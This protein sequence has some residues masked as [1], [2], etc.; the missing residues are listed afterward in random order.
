MDTQWI[1]LARRAME[2]ITGYVGQQALIRTTYCAMVVQ[3]PNRN[4][5]RA[6]VVAEA[7]ASARG[8]VGPL[9]DQ[10]DSRLQVP[11][12]PCA[13]PTPDLSNDAEQQ[14]LRTFENGDATF[15]DGA[16]K[17]VVASRPICGLCAP[18]LRQRGLTVGPATTPVVLTASEAMAS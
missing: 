12:I 1:D 4:N 7:G 14:A 8:I 9:V 15:K 2:V 16:I 5:V 17:A 18:T 3:L 11:I 10:L 13:A 6:V